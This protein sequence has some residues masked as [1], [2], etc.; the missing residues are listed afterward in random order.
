ML[1]HWK[2]GV[3]GFNDVIEHVEGDFD[4]GR[5]SHA[6]LLY[7]PKGVGK[8]FLATRFSAMITGFDGDISSHPDV[9]VVSSDGVNDNISV[10]DIRKISGFLRLTPGNGKWRVVILDGAD[11]MTYSASNAL[12]KILEEPGENTVLFVIATAI[13]R[14][15]PTINSRCVKLYCRAQRSDLMRILTNI[16]GLKDEKQI[17][18]LLNASNQDLGTAIRIHE[19]NAL[20]II[21]KININ[22]LTNDKSTT[23][24]ILEF[25]LNSIDG[26]EITKITVMTA[27]NSIFKNLSSSFDNGGEEV[28]D[29]VSDMMSLLSLCEYSALDKSSVLSCCL[30]QQFRK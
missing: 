30:L 28:F 13:G 7:G 29:K 19:I 4:K 2:E 22:L 14:M 8:F 16:T 18:A 20:P 1:S 15:L 6:Y 25:A 27:L 24:E 10:D 21:E 23:N 9:M 12:L 5:L 3:V 11:Y 26:W 17:I